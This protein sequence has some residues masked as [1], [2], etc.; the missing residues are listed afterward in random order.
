MNYRSY[1]NTIKYNRYLKDKEIISSPTVSLEA[2]FITMVIDV[3]KGLAVVAFDVTGDYLHANFP[4]Y[5][6]VL[7]KLRGEFVDI[8]C[9]VN[10]EHIKNVIYENTQSFYV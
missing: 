7:L 2:L 6:H 10:L 9:G 8:L 5:K 4:K 1:A 3:Y